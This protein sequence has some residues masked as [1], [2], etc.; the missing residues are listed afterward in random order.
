[1][2]KSIRYKNF[3]QLSFIDTLIYSK[4][5]DHPFW[6]HIE[7]KIDFSFADELCSV[8]YSGRGQHPYA[9]SLKLKI[10]LIQTYYDLSDRQTEEKIIGD[11]F[12]KRFLGL[13]V[14]FFGFDH[15]TIGADRQRMGPEMFHACHLYILAQ[16]YSHGLWGEQSEQWI[17]DSFPSNAGVVI[18][19]SYRLIQ[20]GMIRIYQY[21]KRSYPALYQ[22]ACDYLSPDV[23]KQRLG[24]DSS[25]SQ[26]ALA[27]S[28]LA[29][30]AYG[31]LCWFETEQVTLMIQNW[32]KK[33]S[34]QRLLELQ[35]VLKQILEENCRPANSDESMN[36]DDSISN[37]SDKE[38]FSLAYQEETEESVDEIQYEKIP[39][40][41]RPAH[42]IVNA[43]QPD[44]RVAVRPPFK[45]I[46]GYKTQNLC[47]SNGVI[48][49]TR[50]ISA[51]ELDQVAMYS[52]VQDMQAFFRM[53][54]LAILGDTAY[55][56][57]KQRILMDT[58]GI[59]VVA[60]VSQPSGKENKYDMT[61]FTFDRETDSY[62]CP[63]GN[64]TYRKSRMKKSEGY[65]YHFRK[66]ECSECPLRNACTDSKDGRRVFH[67][68]YYDLYEQA[69][70]FNQTDEG[71]LLLRQRKL[72]ER[73][74][75]EL[76][77][78]CGLG[79]PR[80]KS[81]TALQMKATI[82]AIVV[83][84]KLVVRTFFKKP[85]PGFFRRAKLT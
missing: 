5:P 79:K 40:K 1:M 7:S 33:E 74:N 8:L 46:K 75:Q 30:H 2:E 28:K 68:D 77:N 71:Q 63:N 50:V 43:H 60:P 21:L 64:Q 4:L 3:D 58:L 26:R 31:L 73:K 59:P 39:R 44:V 42:R 81:R 22:L 83:N 14:E 57:G 16:M 82:A 11:L 35:A 52:M 54:P 6:S 25:A 53:T 70:E 23:L 37:D 41:G 38:P 69:K 51:S 55:G 24:S 85:N 17:I 13:P 20:Q 61:H 80:V 49:N 67:S 48:L 32:E 27:F 47:T 18:C 45:T 84:L 56:Y 78:D 19:G 34:R 15:S 65:Q 36:D 29:A 10:H 12:I 66:E 76:K 9:P 72:V 62:T